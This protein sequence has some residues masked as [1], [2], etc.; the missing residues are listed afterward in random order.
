MRSLTYILTGR[1]KTRTDCIDYMQTHTPKKISIELMSQ[2]VLSEAFISKTLFA[3]YVWVFKEE[4]VTYQ[5]IYGRC[6]QHE[7]YE[8]QC[9]SIDNSNRRLVKALE[10]LRERTGLSIESQDARFEYSIAYKTT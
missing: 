4:V 3:T 8:R 9:V 2:E 6:F 10:N 7:T 5:E 1:P